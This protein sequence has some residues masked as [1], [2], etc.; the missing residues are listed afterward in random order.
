MRETETVGTEAPETVAD[1]DPERTVFYP[2]DTAG[3]DRAVHLVRGGAVA[4]GEG[5][6]YAG[7]ASLRTVQAAALYADQPVCSVCREVVV[8]E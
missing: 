5:C 1:L 7:R 2:S 4:D 8:D 6:R 3:A